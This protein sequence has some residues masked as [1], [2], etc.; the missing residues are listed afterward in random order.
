MHKCKSISTPMK[1]SSYLDNDEIGRLI[2]VKLYRSM[3]G[4]LLYLTIIRPNIMFRVC[5]CARFQLNPKKSHLKAVKRIFRYL[6]S[7][8]NIELFFLKAS[9]LSLVAYTN[10]DYD[11][12]KINRKSTSDSCHF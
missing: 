12:C 10:T 5:L 1:T 7:F 4:S 11:G 3:I 9:K 6:K 2:D 8:S